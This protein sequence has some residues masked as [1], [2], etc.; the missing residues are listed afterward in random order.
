MEN[1]PNILI[2]FTDDQRF[3]TIHALGNT[4]IHTPN[5]DR[6][7]QMGTA[8][9]QAHIPSGTSGAVCMPSRAMLLTGRFLFRIKGAGETIDPTHI[10]LGEH[11]QRQGYYSY[12]VGKWHNAPP[13]YNRSHNDGSH[14]F[15]GGMHDHWNVPFFGYDPTGKYEGSAPYIDDFFH[16][17]QTKTRKYDFLHHGVHSSEII[18]ETGVKFIRKYV[19]EIQ[20]Q[21]NKPFFLYL[22]F[23]APHDPRT[24]PKRFLEMYNE[25]EMEL[26][27]NFVP[28]HPFENGDLRGRDEKLAAFPRD[29]KEIKRHLKE[30]YAMISHLDFEIGKVID[31]LKQQ[32]LLE[33]TIIVLAGD[34]GLAIGQHG[35]MGK[36]SCY[37]HSNRVPLIFAGPGIPKNTQTD[38]F[39]YLLDIYPTLCNLIDVPIPDTVDGI[40]LV[41]A[42]KNASTP[43]R[44]ALYMAYTKF[45]RAIKTRQYKLIEYVINGRNSQTQLFDLTIDPYEMHNLAENPDHKERIDQLRRQMVQFRDEWEEL[46]TMWGKVWWHGF[47]KSHPEFHDEHTRNLTASEVKHSQIKGTVYFLK[48]GWKILKR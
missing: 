5:M 21:I 42:I 33:N 6:L 13:S 25:T 26:P 16:T 39:A 1:R 47:L 3:D 46:Q 35:L 11:L 28:E 10:M 29:P 27:P 19:S 9:T 18:A 7:V 12:G 34:N 41:P 43:V 17:N 30:Y 15:F 36:Q 32:N 2:L 20:P 4:K 45:Q 44:D 38:A 37:E 23:L 40:N 8:F 14:V 24:M 31:E 22:S 48:E